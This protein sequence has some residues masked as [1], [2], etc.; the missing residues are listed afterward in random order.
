MPDLEP[1][2][3][4]H[5]LVDGLM[6]QKLHSMSPRAALQETLRTISSES[7]HLTRAWPPFVPLL[8]L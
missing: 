4:L 3:V 2:I 1:D 6:A 7:I 5:Y 8:S